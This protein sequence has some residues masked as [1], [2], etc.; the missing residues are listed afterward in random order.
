MSDV[1]QPLGLFRNSVF[2]LSSN[3]LALLAGVVSL[4]IAFRELG[5]DRFALL[6]LLWALLTY[7]TLFDFGI[8]RSVARAAS[9]AI[10][11][12]QPGRIRTILRTAVLI[13]LGIGLTAGVVLLLLVPV[14]LRTFNVPVQYHLEMTN[15]L[16]TLALCLPILLI[17]QSQQAVLEAFER[18]DLLAF[19]RTPVSVATYVTPAIGAVLGWSLAGIL[20]TLLAIR[21]AAGVTMFVLQKPLLP[22]ERLAFEAGGV[23]EILRFG[24]W[25]SLS[26]VIIGVIMYIDR[27]ML[28]AYGDLNAVAQ[29]AAS[30]DLAA[31]LLIIPGSVSTVYF[32]YLA[33]T[34]FRA[35][36]GAGLRNVWRATRTIVMLLLPIVVVLIALAS[37]IL[38][39][40][41][42]PQINQQGITCFQI[43]LVGALLH[44][45]AFMPVMFIES[46]GKSDTVAKY[47]VVELFVYLAVLVIGVRSAGAVGAAWAWLLRSA[48]LVVWAYGYLGSWQRTQPPAAVPAAM[49]SQ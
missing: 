25:L 46:L 33:K 48:W 24:G 8:G 6:A 47:H 9:A 22:A 39:A 17:N 3:L 35:E 44:A 37:Y 16:R 31:K 5:A 2:N 29:Y 36:S 42:G 7:A 14:V 21:I 34:H 12:H 1:K 41:L 28:A 23:R 49:A 18:F 4:P 20:G 45:A 13:Q 40:W 15:A 30:Y 43:L 19:V 11:A 27:M 26:A 38:P 10:A 32:P